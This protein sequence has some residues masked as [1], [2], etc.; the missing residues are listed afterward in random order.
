MVNQDQA[1]R[2]GN[3]VP[4]LSALGDMYQTISIIKIE[5]ISIF[6]EY[7]G[8]P[9]QKK[10]SRQRSQGCMIYQATPIEKMIQ[11]NADK[12]RGKNLLKIRS[13]SRRENGT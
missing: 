6:T 1:V 11:V 2:T 8:N 7:D 13:L 4:A 9:V 10:E 12:E 5:N 3:S